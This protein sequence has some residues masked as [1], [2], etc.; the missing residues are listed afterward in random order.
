M[1]LKVATEAITEKDHTIRARIWHSLYRFEVL[2]S[3][4][5]GRPKSINI[6][7]SSV[8]MDLLLHADEMA[9]DLV[10]S[11]LPSSLRSWQEFL[12]SRRDVAAKF[13]GGMV[14]W[15]YFTH[16]RMYMSENHFIK[17]VALTKVA[18]SMEEKLYLAPQDKTWL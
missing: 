18:D 2:L 15:Q 12:R 1:H 9:I 3:E 6:A 17:A 11:D 8:P 7:N 16:N 10:S 14:A 13:R 5:T 4:M